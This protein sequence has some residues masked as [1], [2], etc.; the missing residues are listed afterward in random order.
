M[1]WFFQT[2]R[3][4]TPIGISWDREG[5]AKYKCLR[6]WRRDLGISLRI[7]TIPRVCLVEGDSVEIEDPRDSWCL[8]SKYQML[9][10]SKKF[11]QTKRRNWDPNRPL[12][13]EFMVEN[14]HFKSQWRK[15][16]IKE[17]TSDL[18]WDIT[19]FLKLYTKRLSSLGLR[20][21]CNSFTLYTVL[22]KV[23]LIISW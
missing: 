16:N 14:Y 22:I 4:S 23:L 7:K 17:R 8:W 9:A 21:L 11:D 19:L 18:N 5:S 6:R 1:S 3:L 20:S 10:V 13:V 15:S 2:Q 12:I